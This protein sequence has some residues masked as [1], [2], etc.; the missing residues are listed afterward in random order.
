M[1]PDR[2]C[3]F[4]FYAVLGPSLQW[5]A[6]FQVPSGNA[7][8]AWLLAYG[9]VDTSGAPS[10]AI[11]PSSSSNSTD[12]PSPKLDAA[13]GQMLVATFGGFADIPPMSMTPPPGWALPPPWIERSSSLS[14]LRRSAIVGDLLFEQ[15]S[16]VQVTAEA[17]GSILPE[18]VTAAIVALS[19]R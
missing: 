5:P 11:G 9:G 14:D 4:V 12:W 7:G 2:A 16:S 3:V 17:D 13:A 18:Y 19:P 6:Q 1:S 15:S 8:F 10:Y